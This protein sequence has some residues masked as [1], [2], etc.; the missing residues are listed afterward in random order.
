M[1]RTAW[2]LNQVNRTLL[3]EIDLE[4]PEEID[5]KNPALPKGRRLRPGMY[6]HT[7]IFAEWQNLLTLPASA[8]VTE[9][10]VTVGYQTFCCLIEDGR[11]KRIPIEIGARNEQLVEILKKRVPG[12]KDGAMPRWEEFTGNET[13]AARA[14]GLTDGQSVQLDSS[15]K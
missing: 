14:T 3:T 6:V 8:V 9:G 10:D 12:A 5:R 15:K 13:V 2:S 4:N 1:T 11:V 7:T